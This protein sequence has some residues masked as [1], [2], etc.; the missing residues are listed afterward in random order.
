MLWS[1]R[2]IICDTPGTVLCDSCR[3]SLPYIDQWRACPKCGAPFGRLLCTECNSFTLADIGRHNLP[4]D[5]CVSVIE[6]AGDAR[7][8]ATG[9]KDAGEQ[10]LAPIIA[11]LI[12]D[13]LP[14]SW[15]AAQPVLTFIPATANAR[16]T[17]GFDHGQAI[18]E[19]LAERTGLHCRGLFERPSSKDQRALSRKQRFSNMDERF[20]LSPQA[21][22]N[23]PS[24]VIL[25]DDV[26]TT[27][28]T[29]FAASDALLEAGIAHI[30]CATF[31]RVW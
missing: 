5:R 16:R 9:C 1:T 6:H 28:A 7:R 30:D 21:R 23:A 26:Y 10:R 15:V 11:Q 8:I 4:F 17:R 25:I 19:A 31:S 29:L 27:G 12:A 13:V 24:R 3:M 22:A 14:P 20:T 2:C 18:A